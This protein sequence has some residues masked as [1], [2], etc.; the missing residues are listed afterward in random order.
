[1]V[2]LEQEKVAFEER[3]AI[4]TNLL[5]DKME[6]LK[7]DREQV[8]TNHRLQLEALEQQLEQH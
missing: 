2:G 1:L 6:V 8:E 4:G 3:L 5:M 7:S